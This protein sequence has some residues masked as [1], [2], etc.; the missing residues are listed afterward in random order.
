MQIVYN[1][2]ERFK[3][4]KILPHFYTDTEHRSTSYC[5]QLR[6]IRKYKS[7]RN[8]NEYTITFLYPFH[9]LGSEPSHLFSFLKVYLA[10]FRHYYYI[11]FIFCIGFLKDPQA[12]FP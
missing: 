5:T 6:R 8:R 9:K 3:K 12:M 2:Y 7:V 4:L 11:G 1:L 10:I